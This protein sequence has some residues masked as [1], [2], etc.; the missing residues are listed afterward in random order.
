MSSLNGVPRSDIKIFAAEQE[1][2][3]NQGGESQ[4]TP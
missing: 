2:Q 3:Y 1:V 4:A